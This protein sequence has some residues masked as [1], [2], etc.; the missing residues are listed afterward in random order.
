MWAR[1]EERR[2]LQDGRGG[3]GVHFV[4]DLEGSMGDVFMSGRTGNAAWSGEN[5]G[6]LSPGM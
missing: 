4:E 1:A 2:G 6:A 5:L 3:V